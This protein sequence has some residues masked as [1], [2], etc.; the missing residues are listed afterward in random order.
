LWHS[1]CWLSSHIQPLQRPGDCWSKSV[2]TGV[3]FW[4]V[5]GC[6]AQQ[7]LP[8]LWAQEPQLG[9][10]PWDY[11]NHERTEIFDDIC[12]LHESLGSLGSKS[13]RLRNSAQYQTLRKCI[14]TVMH[15]WRKTA[16]IAWKKGYKYLST[17][18]LAASRRKLEN[19]GV[20]SGFMRGAAKHHLAVSF[21]YTSSDVFFPLCQCKTLC[22]NV[23]TWLI[24]NC[25][26]TYWTYCCLNKVWGGQTYFLG[27][28]V[29][30][31]KLPNWKI[32]KPN[33]NVLWKAVSGLRLVLV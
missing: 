33:R 29:L 31:N 19:F 17:P 27:H 28:L 22:P 13:L 32:R 3:G 25:P 1:S 4:P 23:D 7:P 2:A 8:D 16:Q 12:T 30:W 9:E 11:H 21:T 24:N 20:F 10:A 18:L 15:N 14:R 26:K 5:S 6:D